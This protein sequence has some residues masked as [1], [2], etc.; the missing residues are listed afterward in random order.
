MKNQAGVG[1][2]Q[3]AAN[4]FEAGKEA[5]EKALEQAGGGKVNLVVVFSTEQFEEGPMLQGIQTITGDASLIGCTAASIIAN[6]NIYPDAVGVA[7]MCSEDMEVSV[8]LVENLSR[9]A[10]EA[11][12]Q[13]AQ[14]LLKN[15][16][17]SEGPHNTQV[18]LMLLDASMT[19][20]IV[21]EVIDGA[22]KIL[23]AS[24]KFVG[25]GS[26]DNLHFKKSYQFFN[27][28]AYSDSAV[29]ARI[30]T[31]TPQAVSLKHGWI[32]TGTNLIVTKAEGKVVK[33]FDGQPALKVY[34][35]LLKED[36]S[37]FDFTKFYNFASGHPLGVPAGREEFII[38]DPLSASLEDNSITFVS[39]VPE[40]SIVQLMEGTPESLLEASKQATTKA[41]ELLAG[42]AP[43]IILIADCVSRLLFL[44]SDAKTEIENIKID[45]KDDTPMLGFFSFG[46]VG[47]EK[48]GAPAFYNKTCGLYVLPK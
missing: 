14:Q 3:N 36:I 26:S 6:K 19:K 20:G 40:N 24:N 45:G 4:S 15:A 33:E 44:G 22:Y 5:A 42:A 28:K 21:S 2:S 16:P 27:G 48:G 7:V 30:V 1:I 34:M 47:I 10:Q 13:L 17:Q 25:G 9:D 35:D 12:R 46:E 23:G 41:Q 29:A 31:K 38:R 43:M 11:G 39:E 37:K 32:P 8:G 18:V